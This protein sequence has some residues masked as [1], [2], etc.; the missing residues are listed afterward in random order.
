MTISSFKSSELLEEIKANRAKLEACK[1][2]AFGELP[3]FP[4]KINQKICCN[5]CGGW[6]GMIEASQYTLGYESAG[7]N[8]NEIIAGFR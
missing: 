6:L 4:W 7:G 8:P 2:H 5:A 1:R 3:D